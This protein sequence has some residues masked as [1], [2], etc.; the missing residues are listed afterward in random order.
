M[1]RLRVGF[2]YTCHVES[3]T[4]SFAFP[5]TKSITFNLKVEFESKG[6][7]SSAHFRLCPFLL[8]E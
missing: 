3:G 8:F 7:G 6:A 2:G 4:S 5:S 1:C